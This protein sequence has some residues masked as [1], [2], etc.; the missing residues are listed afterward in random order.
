MRS[1]KGIAI[2]AMILV[3][4]VIRCYAAEF[5]FR[6]VVLRVDIVKTKRANGVHLRH[7]AARIGHQH[8]GIR[9]VTQADIE[10]DG[11][12]CR[13]NVIYSDPVSACEYV[14]PEQDVVVMTATTTRHPARDILGAGNYLNR[15]A[16][17]SLRA[18]SCI[19]D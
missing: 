11:D 18:L 4:S 9:T 16:V 7:G 13:I 15:S 5:M 3:T 8:P 12:N 2:L 19:S 14:L 1:E 6:G 10:D 17:P